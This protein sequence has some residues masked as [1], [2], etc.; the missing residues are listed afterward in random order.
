MG[1][2]AG[3][4][5]SPIS[6]VH[7]VTLSL[8]RLGWVRLGNGYRM[9]GCQIIP[10][11]CCAPSVHPNTR[12][13]VETGAH[14]I[15]ERMRLNSSGPCCHRRESAAARADSA[16]SGQ[17]RAP[18]HTPRSSQTP[19]CCIMAGRKR[20][21]S[22]ATTG[23]MSKPFRCRSWKSA[24]KKPIVLPEATTALIHLEYPVKRA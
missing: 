24:H 7:G 12:A 20:K 8:E 3:W 9:V 10:H 19:A 4:I 18:L 21:S 6:P 17:P 15:P 22:S 13:L 16:P 23:W 1:Q 11:V 14:C 5:I 2:A